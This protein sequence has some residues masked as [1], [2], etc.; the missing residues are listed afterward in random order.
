MVTKNPTHQ[1]TIALSTTLDTTSI[2]RLLVAATIS[3][4]FCR[5]L[6]ND[7]HSA[8]QAGFNGEY[9]PLSQTTYSAINSVKA[10]TLS[11][12]IRELNDKV[13]PPLI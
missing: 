9:F 13:T 7:P 2:N 11:D 1:T 8:I 6:L 10:V 4:G 12:F 3:P 5:K